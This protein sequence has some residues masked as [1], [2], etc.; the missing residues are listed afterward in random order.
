L[1]LEFLEN[2]FDLFS[3]T[4]AINHQ[5]H[6]VSRFSRVEHAIKIIERRDPDIVECHDYVGMPDSAP[7]NVRWAKPR[8]RRRTSRQGF[9]NNDSLDSPLGGLIL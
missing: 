3:T 7:V 8:S 4:V 9:A 6:S 1:L 5:R 2:Q